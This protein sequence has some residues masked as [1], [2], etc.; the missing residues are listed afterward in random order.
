MRCLTLAQELHSRGWLCV[1]ATNA[2][3][4]TV[5]PMLEVPWIKHVSGFDLERGG[6]LR[7]I[8][9]AGRLLPA[10]A[11]L[12]VI[13]HYGSTPALEQHLSEYCRAVLAVDDFA[14]PSPLTASR[15]HCSILLNPNIGSSAEDY[16]N[17][18]PAGTTLLCGAQ[19]TLVRRAL[20]EVASTRRIEDALRPVRRV[21]LS[22]GLTDAGAITASVAKWMADRFPDLALDAIIGPKAEGRDAITALT[23]VHPNLTVYIDPANMADLLARA[24]LAIGAAGQSSYERCCFALP[25][26][27]VVVAEN[28]INLAEALRETHGVMV[29]D[30]REATF[31]ADLCDQIRKLI[32]DPQ[33]RFSMAKAA[34]QTCDG[35]GAARVADG[36]QTALAKT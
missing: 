8:E 13:D 14:R 1:F 4:E 11:D 28:Q 31:E 24:D 21:V 23:S 27:A 5:V 15:R 6:V 12:I 3:A 20:A 36:I 34:R 29:L 25:S 22:F 19:F 9:E 17:R 10:R 7:L 18:V 35:R 33:L 26:I 30:R 16:Y 2:G 32:K